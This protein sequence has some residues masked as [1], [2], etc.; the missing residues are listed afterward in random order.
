MASELRE[1]KLKEPLRIRGSDRSGWSKKGD[2]VKL[3]L[4]TAQQYH[5]FLEPDPGP[6]PKAPPALR[7]PDRD[8]WMADQLRE[9]AKKDV[10]H[11]VAAEEAK[12]AMAEESQA[13]EP[14]AAAEEAPAESE[15]APAEPEPEAADEPEAEPEPDE[16]EN[17]E[18]VKETP[19]KPT[20]RRRKSSAKAK[21]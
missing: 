1:Y 9:T 3:D 20:R 16:P 21:S 12:E 17:D 10:P 7:D 14:E 11:A 2:T 6:R 8:R 13:E 5:Q 19:K 15:E 18:E 4:K